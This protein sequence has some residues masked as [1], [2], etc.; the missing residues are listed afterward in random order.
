MKNGRLI[1]AAVGGLLLGLFLSKCKDDTITGDNGSPS[2]VVFPSD[3][4]VS[5]TQHVQPLFNQ[6]C[7]LSG[8]HDD[9]EHQSQLKLTNYGNTVTSLP[10]VV[11]PRQP[12]QSTLVLRIEGRV[13]QRMPLNRNPLNQNQITGIRLWVGAGAKNN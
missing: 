6:T 10:G 12:D 11:V 9:G 5:Y 2:N 7:A 13:G 1:V 8:C 4:T 3:T